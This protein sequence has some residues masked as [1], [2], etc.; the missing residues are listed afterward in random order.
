[1]ERERQFWTAKQWEYVG[2]EA[3]ENQ[4]RERKLWEE[5][6]CDSRSQLWGWCGKMLKA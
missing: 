1:M 3:L 2:L 4:R 5:G 6:G